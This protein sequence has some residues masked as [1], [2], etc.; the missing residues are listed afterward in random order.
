M[1]TTWPANFPVFQEG[2]DRF[3]EQV[4]EMSDGRL[5]IQVYAG[6]ELVPALQSFD[7]VSQGT[8]EVGHGASY[9][10]SGKVPAAQFFSAVPF[11]M[12][13]KGVE[14]WIYFGGGLEIWRELYEPLML[15]QYLW[16]IPVCRRAAGSTRG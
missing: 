9:Y 3:A 4:K 1:V 6:G 12:T 5:N 13:A 10:W 14:T 8:I 16:V 15:F 11:G 2:A 7:A